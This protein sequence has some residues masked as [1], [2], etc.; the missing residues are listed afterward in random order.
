MPASGWPS[1]SL[2]D[3]QG[4][5]ATDLWSSF[6]LCHQIVG[7]GSDDELDAKSSAGEARNQ[8]QGRSSC[9]PDEPGLS[10]L[11]DQHPGAEGSTKI[12]NENEAVS[13]DA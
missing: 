12:A 7:Q 9:Q 3:Q 6:E 13:P 5:F 11:S 4:E 1:R 2:S 10:W 8:L